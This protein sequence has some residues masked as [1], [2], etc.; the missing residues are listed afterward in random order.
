MKLQHTFIERH[1]ASD[2]LP[3]ART[4]S[5]LCREAR[6]VRASHPAFNSLRLMALAAPVL[7]ALSLSAHAATLKVTSLADD[8]GSAG[9]LR[10]QIE[11]AAADD[12]IVFD[13]SGTIALT[14][15]GLPALN[16]NLTITGSM[17]DGI[18][19][20]GD[21]EGG[22]FSVTAGKITI[23]NLSIAD[24]KAS[25]GN[26]GAVSTLDPDG[27][28]FSNCTFSGNSASSSNGKGTGGAIYNYSGGVLMLT[29]CTFYNNS[30]SGTNG[31]GGAIFN[32]SATLKMTN[33]TVAGN[34]S[35][36]DASGIYDLGTATLINT[37]VAGN[38][39]QS[40]GTNYAGRDK[41]LANGSSNNIIE[42]TAWAAGL[43]CYDNKNAMYLSNNG[44]PTLTIG[45]V[46]GGA[47]VD[48]GIPNLATDQ[49][50]IARPQ[51]N[52]SD[53][54][55]FEL[56]NFGGRRQPR[57]RGGAPPASD[58]VASP[59]DT[60]NQNPHGAVAAGPMEP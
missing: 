14:K 46:Q 17:K 3:G 23:S 5:R 11:A 13:V 1:I 21:K 49:R 15:G 12:T 42:G 22:I 54:G 9:T 41:N 53:I 28:T 24:G 45:L 26:G 33:C 36:K 55:A 25:S 58:P 10:G 6:S 2:T 27:L 37:I 48:A 18:T 34:T 43:E 56:Q 4:A 8:D 60:F 7:C 44:G 50:G 20:K 51:G 32:D 47:A 39:S 30:A 59:E 57:R 52:A 31:L 16:K 38:T 35:S 29:N 19:I 40:G